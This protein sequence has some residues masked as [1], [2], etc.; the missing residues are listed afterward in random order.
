MPE[1]NQAR[2][3]QALERL[4]AAGEKLLADNQFEEASVAEIARLAES[5]VGT[6]YRLLGDKDTLSLLL[7]QR[8]MQQLA[9]KT[10]SLRGQGAIAGTWPRVCAC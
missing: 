7:L 6:F 9:D 1:P 10:A 5:S 4:L 3:R 8:F 2:S